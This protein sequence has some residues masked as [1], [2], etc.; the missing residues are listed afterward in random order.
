M[1]PGAALYRKVCNLSSLGI[2]DRTLQ[3]EERFSPLFPC[4]S[5]Y[6]LNIFRIVYLHIL[7][8]HR[9]R[10]RGEFHFL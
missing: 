1:P 7:K 3:H 2:E 4:G 5:E 6:T 9:Q 10:V 8:F